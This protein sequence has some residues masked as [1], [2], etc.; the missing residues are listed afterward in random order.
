MSDAEDAGVD[1][2]AAACLESRPAFLLVA[3]M[4]A[5][6]TLEAKLCFPPAWHLKAVNRTATFES[7][8]HHGLSSVHRR[9]FLESRLFTRQGE[10][11][12]VSQADT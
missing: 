3:S 9:S 7:A 11:P 12:F 4:L 1:P 2:S 8:T 6:S 5:E 10:V